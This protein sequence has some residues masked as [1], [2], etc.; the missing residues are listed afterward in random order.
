MISLKIS[1]IK[2]FMSKLL[3]ENDTTFD[4]FLVAEATIATFNTFH[5]DGHINHDFYRNDNSID[6]I[7]ESEEANSNSLLSTSSNKFASPE[8][9][10]SVRPDMSAWKTLKPIC[11]ALIKGK[12]TP[13]HFRFVFHLSPENTTRFLTQSA[14]EIGH[15]FS[16]ENVT[17]LILN[18]KYDGNALTCIT[19]T[20]LNIFTMDK[21]LEHAWDH[22]IQKFF[23][24]QG[25]DFTEEI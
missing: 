17:G 21:S 4:T 19:A 10:S 5:I 24:Q 16:P 13:L 25:I 9:S 2:N 14:D 6:T 1:D 11:F 22:M 23:I 7:S 15:E 8:V 18:I 20:S 3:H 12:R